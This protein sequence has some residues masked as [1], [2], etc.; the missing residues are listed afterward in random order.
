[1]REKGMKFLIQMT[2]AVLFKLGTFISFSLV[3]S[4]GMKSSLEVTSLG[5]FHLRLG[6]V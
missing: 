5:G 6:G 3:V 4:Y 1:M 2:C